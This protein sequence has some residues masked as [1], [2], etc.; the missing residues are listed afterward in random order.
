MLSGD[1]SRIKFWGNYVEVVQ[2]S[3]NAL[4]GMLPNQT[5]QFLRLTRL[6]ISNNS[7]EGALPP[8]LGSY[9]ELKEIDLSFNLLSGSLLP[10]FF[11]STKLTKLNLSHNK[12]SGSISIQEVR[13]NP[14]VGNSG[15]VSL[16]LSFNNLSGLLPPEIS[17]LHNLESL[18]L[19]NNQFEGTIP[20]ELP[21]ELREFNVSFN[22]FSGA[23]PDKL[24]KFPESA[25]HPGNSLLIFSHSP[26]TPKDV[27]DLGQSGQGPHMKS[28]TRIAL[29]AS[30][31]SG[32]FVMAVVVITIYYKVHCQNQTTSEE[33]REKNVAQESS[34]ASS[35]REVPNRKVEVIS[36][37][38]LYPNPKP[39]FQKGSADD[40]VVKTT[41][42]FDSSEFVKNDEGISSPMSFLSASNPS[43]SRSHPFENS[44]AL[45]I[46]SPEKSVGDLNLFDGSLELTAE[47]FSS[48]TAEVI[49]RSCHGALYKA[50]LNSGHV[51]AVKML[52]DGI[53]KNKKEFAREVRKLGT[54]K[55][56]SLVSL[57]GYYLGPKESD[58]FIISNFINAQSLDFCLHG[59]ILNIFFNLYMFVYNMLILLHF[60]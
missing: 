38:N 4:T 39:S 23:V 59:K 17:R 27:A 8:V 24:M 48:A 42:D 45:K 54:I 11:A 26:I 37:S 57:Q 36:S 46:C 32:A 29:I 43:S 28:T 50:T 7:L 49:G 10:S 5:S 6:E 31:V 16:D 41:K 34:L 58:K 2:L 25:F 18:D 30:L 53:A 22:N 44:N 14:L 47:E 33:S 55:H 9:P 60:C 40:A 3:S 35:G 21:D 13:D 20:N 56:P 19:C 1:L 51:L 52:K 15:L 12:I